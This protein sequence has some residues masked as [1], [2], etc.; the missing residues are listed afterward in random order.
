V[1]RSPSG[2][3]VVRA[4][5]ER[6]G[7]VLAFFALALALAVAGVA[8][9]IHENKRVPRDNSLE[10][11]FLEDDPALVQYREFLAEWGNDE[12]I[13]VAVF[14]KEG[15]LRP[16]TLELISVLSQRIAALERVERVTSL[17]TVHSVRNAGA[18][19]VEV[20]RYFTLPFDPQRVSAVAATIRKDPLYADFLLSP[21]GKATVLSVQ[22]ETSRDFD[23]QRKAILGSVRA[24]LRQTLSERGR[25][26]EGWAWGGIG[27][28]HVALNTLVMSDSAKFMVLTNLLVMIGLALAF[29]RALA[30]VACL[31]SVAGAT[32]LLIGAY[33][34]T[35]FSLNMV[36]MVLPTLVM[37]VG[38]T[39]SV[40]FLTTFQL[41]R[42]REPDLE[43][44]E[45]V[46]Q[47]LG[48]CFWPGLFNSITTSVG[49]LAFLVAP[50][51]VV[52][53]L[54]V[55]AGFGV[56]CAFFA[57]LTVC[58]LL[59]ERFPDRIERPQEE[60][61]SLAEGLVGRGLARLAEFAIARRKLLLALTAVTAC[62]AG[63]GISRLVVDSYSLA[64]FHQDHEIRR[65]DD[66]LLASIGPYL[67]LE[68]VVR[69]PQPEGAKRADVLRGIES[70]IAEVVAEEP[71]VRRAT[72]LPAVVKRLT[73]VF[74]DDPQAEIPTDP[75]AIQQLLDFYDPRRAED[76]IWLVDEAWQ[77]TRFQFQIKNEGAGAG[78]DLLARIHAR[79]PKHLPPDVELISGGYM[80]LYAKLVEHLVWSQVTSI[81]ITTLVVFCL[82]ALLFRSLRYALISFLPNV[83]P[84]AM[85]LAL[86][87]YLGIRLD[88]AT[89]MVAAIALG[90]AVDDTIH[91][92]YK[93]RAALAEC[94]DPEQAVRETITST[95]RAIFSTSLIVTLGFS[96][97]AFASIK[98]V[99]LFGLLLCATMLSALV[100]EFLV[101]P[102]LIL[103]FP[104]QAPPKV[105]D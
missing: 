3:R 51:E 32:I 67:P 5:L 70:L 46:V 41:L 22:L 77:E 14:D 31:L 33:L 86:M 12:A 58:A 13:V 27:V 18:D 10:I 34:G 92:L 16:E 45:A 36:T 47:S 42:A 26:P 103:A 44:R 66:A 56:G 61:R 25:D 48:F 11:W 81:A 104:P 53:H 94:G 1:I 9:S 87:G 62:L 40:Y 50:M 102:A 24:T 101:T 99:S 74:S 75:A 80:P 59:I 79:A 68:L 73:R 93:F 30:V 97:L 64:Y 69:T 7:A 71:T 96:A 60:G 98:T 90:V 4:L 76:P 38:L 85:T 84:V 88:M 21:D 72:S 39:D 35:G 49:F 8:H 91:F 20:D 63:Y 23:Q 54:G 78:R 65:H 2:E 82:I 6:R 55:F 15:V 37:V 100:A 43:V 28:I 19:T 52:R 17:S 83:L 57:S 105:E 95:G 29:R 89:V